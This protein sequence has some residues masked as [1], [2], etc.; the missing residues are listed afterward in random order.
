L[1]NSLTFTNGIIIPAENIKVAPKYSRGLGGDFKKTKEVK[2][3][4][5][6]IKHT[7][8]FNNS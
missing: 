4:K 2:R 1:K 5:T 3:K 6:L 7:V 8:M